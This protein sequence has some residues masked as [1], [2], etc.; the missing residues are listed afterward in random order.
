ML[1]CVP[2]VPL[3]SCPAAAR[4]HPTHPLPGPSLAPHSWSVAVVP[5]SVQQTTAAISITPPEFGTFDFYELSV[6]PKPAKGDPEWQACPK[7]N[8][9][10]N[11]VR[12][13]PACLPAGT[14]LSA[15]LSCLSCAG[16]AGLAGL[17]GVH[18]AGCPCKVHGPPGAPAARTAGMTR[19]CCWEHFSKNP[20]SSINRPSGGQLRSERPGRRHCLCGVWHGLHWRPAGQ[21]PLLHRLLHHQTLAVSATVCCG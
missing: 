2:Q 21:R 19:A 4:I 1:Q 17:A 3:G 10:P 6:C 9:L 11:Q 13:P 8:C 5:D 20:F 12:R 18:C 14:F 16:L 7:T 15:C